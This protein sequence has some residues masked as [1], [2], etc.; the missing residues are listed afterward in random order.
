L[1]AVLFFGCGRIGFVPLDLPDGG[2]DAIA[3]SGDAPD[4]ASADGSA[5]D[6]LAVVEVDGQGQIVSDPPGILCPGTCA[7]TFPRGTRVTLTASPTAPHKFLGWDSAE[8]YGAP[9]CAILAERVTLT[10]A[11]FTGAYNVAFVSTDLVDPTTQTPAVADAACARSATN[12][13][14]PGTYVAW[15]S[16]TSTNAVSRLGTAS[17]WL[18]PDGLPFTATRSSLLAGAI[19]YPIRYSPALSSNGQLVFT[20]TQADGTYSGRDCAN[21]STASAQATTGETDAASSA[22]TEAFTLECSQPLPVLCFG[23]DYQAAPPLLGHSGRTAF[24]A[25]PWQPGGGLADADA[26]CQADAGAAGLTGSYRALLSHA[27]GTA[28]DRF[29][30][31]GPTWVNRSGIRIV[32]VASMLGQTPFLA[33][34][35]QRADGTRSS[36]TFVFTGSVNASCSDWTDAASSS[37]VPGGQIQRPLF[38][39]DSAGLFCNMALPIYCLEQ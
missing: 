17:G 33:P 10:A 32:P 22:F 30:G 5:T 20:A 18:T 23:I 2:L 14:W 6:P 11:R 9:T 27:G 12:A 26:H 31:S 4:G 21:W 37:T 36:E 13:G 1:A 3:A 15:M 38:Y 25:T 7:A 16:T 29:D 8:C 28:A 35:D 39:W 24:L 19:V 34:L